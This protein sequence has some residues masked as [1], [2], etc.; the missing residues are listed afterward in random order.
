[1][2]AQDFVTE[3]SETNPGIVKALKAKGYKRLGSGVDQTAFVEP[4]TGH[5]LKVF[6]TQCTRRGAK[7]TL[8]ADQK[9]FKLWA[10]FCAKNQNNPHLPRIYDWDT[11]VWNE[12]TYDYRSGGL[13]K[14]PCLYLQ[15][16]TE[17]LKHVPNA[18]RSWLDQ[19]SQMAGDNQD[20]DEAFNYLRYHDLPSLERYVD[21][22]GSIQNLKSFYNTM[23]ALARMGD[24][25]GWVWDLHPGNIMQRAD[26]TLVIND[27]WV[28]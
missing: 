3:Y 7:P 27:P 15:I 20:F 25:Q 2:R 12:E 4:G 6:G 9:M 21:R 26:G 14:E 19:L 5:V 23:K 1:M 16:R 11:F 18:Y 24:K 28:I 22:P 17:P 13:T 10:E 8:S